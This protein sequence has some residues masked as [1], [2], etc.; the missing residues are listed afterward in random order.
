MKKLLLILSLV[1]F[2]TL[3]GKAQKSYQITEVRRS[4]YTNTLGW[5]FGENIYTD[6]TLTVNGNLVTINDQANSNYRLGEL[7]K[8]IDDN[9]TKEYRYDA[10]DENNFKVMF[11]VQYD[12][13]EKASYILILYPTPSGSI[14]YSYKY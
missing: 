12:K 1:L 11:T 13:T 14:M 6:M 4:V 9:K 5:K 7:I 10:T 8:H 2:F 3:G